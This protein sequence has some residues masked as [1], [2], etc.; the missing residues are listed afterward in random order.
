M[1]QYGAVGDVSLFQSLGV[2]GCWRLD[3]GRQQHRNGPASKQKVPWQ[4]RP[5]ARSFSPWN[6]AEKDTFR[7]PRSKPDS[8]R[9]TCHILPYSNWGSG[10]TV[11]DKVTH[12]TLEHM[13]W[14]MLVIVCV[15][16]S[17]QEQCW[18]SG[19]EP[20]KLCGSPRGTSC[21]MLRRACGCHNLRCT[22]KCFGGN[23]IQ[24]LPE[25]KDR[26]SSHLFVPQ[27]TLLASRAQQRSSKR[28]R[29]ANL[30]VQLQINRCPG[31]CFLLNM[32]SLGILRRFC[33]CKWVGNPVTKVSLKI[34]SERI[35]QI[36]NPGDRK[37]MKH[38]R[39]NQ[40]ND[41]S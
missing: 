35:E 26:H 14:W 15:T 38:L 29:E 30:N 19:E 10:L 5:Q 34:L 22:C 11:Q 37:N 17:T 31:R 6:L 40:T 41:Q 8:T 23:T 16:D 18:G 2:K 39:R 33:K 27:S 24:V 9:L 13:S 3:I 36:P 12:K 28:Q 25:D 21:I 1:V 4:T 20:R 32:N 7:R